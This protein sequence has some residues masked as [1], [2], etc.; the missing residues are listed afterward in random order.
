MNNLLT[1]A[2]AKTFIALFLLSATSL[3]AHPK[4]PTKP[5]SFEAVCY[6]N[7]ANKIRLAIAKTT[8]EP[9]R[10]TLH[11]AGQS[12]VLF[13]QHIGRKQTKVAIQFNV[14][15]LAD[16]LYELEIQSAT[17][18]IVK[19]VRLSSNTQVVTNERLLAIQ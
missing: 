19:Q 15:D 10:I 12:Y 3:L 7:N 17:S 4:E 11:E 14:S 1:A 9:L 13:A 5:A 18:R 6:V 16:G 8:A 2:F